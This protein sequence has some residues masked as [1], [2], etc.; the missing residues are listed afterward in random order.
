MRAVGSIWFINLHSGH[1]ETIVE[2]FGQSVLASVFPGEPC[3]AEHQCHRRKLL[4]LL[5]RIRHRQ[6]RYCYP[7]RRILVIN[8]RTEI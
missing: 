6:N 5:R 2:L 1:L 4:P 3:R 7:R 8:V